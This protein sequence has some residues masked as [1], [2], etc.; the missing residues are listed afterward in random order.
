MTKSLSAICIAFIMALA[1]VQGASLRISEFLAENDGG[2]VDQDGE[3]PDWIEIQNT[4]ASVVNLAGWRLTD[5][6]TNL[7]KWIFPATNL[8]AGG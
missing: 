6:Q 5:N 2:L 4:T 8:S 3:S 7:T 1:S